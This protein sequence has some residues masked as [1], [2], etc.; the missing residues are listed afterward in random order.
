MRELFS[1]RPY[2]LV[3]TVGLIQGIG[4]FLLLNVP[5]RFLELGLSEGTIGLIYSGA[6]LAGLSLRPLLGRTLDVVHRRTVIRVAGVVNAVAVGGVALASIAG[7][8]LFGWFVVAR[9]SQIAVATATLTYAAD[10]L[11]PALRTRGLAIF[12]LSGLIPIGVANL[13]GD[14][15]IAAAGYTGAIF[16]SA[17]LALLASLIVWWLPALPILGERA[18]RSFWAA[19]AQPDLRIVWFITFVFAMGMESL[20]AFMRAFV[21]SHPDIGSLGGFFGVYGLF[22]VLSRLTTGTRFGVGG[23]RRT[24]A[25]GVAGMGGALL[26][27]AFASGQGAFLAAAVLGGLAHGVVFPLLS[28]EV[29]GRARTAERG[30][31]VTTFTAVFDVAILGIVPV[32]GGV[33]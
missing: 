24:I 31:A 18:R 17:V 28:T 3:W 4:F 13:I 16:T 10:T 30:S 14:R 9:A 5:G 32:V 6:A 2:A 23:P 26:L 12:G 8:V 20:F 15:I 22:A 27:L 11:P 29:V 33:I 19:L 21:D 7:P 25:G 1:I